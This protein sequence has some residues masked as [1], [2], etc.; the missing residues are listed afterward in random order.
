[1]F[2]WPDSAY[3]SGACSSTSW[4]HQLVLVLAVCFFTRGQPW[5]KLMMN[6]LLPV[7]FHSEDSI[8]RLR[9]MGRDVR[10]LHNQRRPAIHR[11]GLPGGGG[12]VGG[13]QGPRGLRDHSP[14]PWSAGEAQSG[15][16][17]S[18]NSGR[19]MGRVGLLAASGQVKKA[20]C[21]WASS[22]H[23]K[24]YQW[25]SVFRPWDRVSSHTT[26]CLISW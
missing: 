11:G 9:C 17:S 8:V 13:W 3:V 21:K 4:H 18:R 26:L 12:R 10:V 16:W 2:Y 22:S 23:G 25:Q 20:F 15:P 6:A 24:H 1:M 14:P 7:M 19:E 5:L